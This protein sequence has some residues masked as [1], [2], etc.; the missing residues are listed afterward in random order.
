MLSSGSSRPQVSSLAF[1]LVAVFWVSLL[2]AV[3]VYFYPHHINTLYLHNTYIT[4]QTGPL[5]N[6]PHTT[7]A[8]AVSQSRP[9]SDAATPNSSSS[10]ES[11]MAHFYHMCAPDH[12]GAQAT[13]K[14]RPPLVHAASTT[15][16]SNHPSTE[17]DLA[18][19][20]EFDGTGHAYHYADVWPSVSQGNISLQTVDNY[21]R[22]YV[23]EFN[24]D[25]A[26]RQMTFNMVREIKLGTTYQYQWVGGELLTWWTR[27]SPDV[28]LQCAHAYG[29]DSSMIELVT[30]AFTDRDHNPQPHCYYS[31]TVDT[32]QRIPTFTTLRFRNKHAA[33]APTVYP[34]TLP[35]FVEKRWQEVERSH[36]QAQQ[37]HATALAS[38][39]MC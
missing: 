8:Q 19:L 32:E 36:K 15:S 2:T 17:V 29:S 31:T 20:R 33:G 35:E 24:V 3:T 34:L 27:N 13:A 4:A 11:G 38:F 7:A 28:Q 39:A 10:Q 37:L 5:L 30:D 25:E 26:R 14:P 6:N 9:C 1:I 18:R 16:H 22:V 12:T 23:M 21:L